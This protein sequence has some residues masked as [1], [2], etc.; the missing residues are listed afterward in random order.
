MSLT[1]SVHMFT[2]ALKKRV[3]DSNLVNLLTR[4]HG[5]DRYADLLAPKWTQEEARAQLVATV[6]DPVPASSAADSDRSAA[7][8]VCSQRTRSSS[9]DHQRRSTSRVSTAQT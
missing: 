7:P 5:L 2:E 9:A 4:P 8:R 1:H 6:L 3:L